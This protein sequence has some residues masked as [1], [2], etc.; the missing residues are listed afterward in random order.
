MMATNSLPRGNSPASACEGKT[1]FASADQA[2]R[3]FAKQSK[4]KG[5]V[6]PGGPGRGNVHVYRCNYCHQFHI[7]STTR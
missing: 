1:T 6:K 5:G 3:A 2:H 7:G 4:R